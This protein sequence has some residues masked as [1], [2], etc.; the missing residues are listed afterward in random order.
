MHDVQRNYQQAKDA[1]KAALNDRHT[2]I[3]TIYEAYVNAETELLKWGFEQAD[4]R[5]IDLGFGL[6][7]GLSMPNKTAL[8]SLFMRF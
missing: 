2:P 4:K 3:V 5:G 6:Y 7:T 8:I 1:Y